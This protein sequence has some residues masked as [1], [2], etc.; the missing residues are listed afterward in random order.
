MRLATAY[1]AGSNYDINDASVEK[2]TRTALKL[3]QE[4][5]ELLIVCGSVFLM[6]GARSALGYNEPRD[7][8]FVAKEAGANLRKDLQEHF[9]NR[10]WSEDEESEGE[11]EREFEEF[12]EGAQSNAIPKN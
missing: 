6:A 3:A 8:D 2:Q 11:I 10:V 4:N 7:S 5:T 1:V 9:G 12:L